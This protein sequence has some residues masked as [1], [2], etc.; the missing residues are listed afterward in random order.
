VGSTPAGRTKSGQ[1]DPKI[2]AKSKCSNV[3]DNAGF[4]QRIYILM[5]TVQSIPAREDNY[6]YMIHASG[7]A[8]LIDPCEAEPCLRLLEHL[9]LKLTH[10]LITHYD[11]DHIGGLETLTRR[12]RPFV[13]GPSPASVTIDKPCRGGDLIV[14]GELT[15]R[16]IDTPGHARPHVAFYEETC[17]WLFSGDCLFGAGCGRVSG[18]AYD[19][20]WKSIQSITSLPDDTLIFFGHEYTLANLAFAASVEPGN[21]AIESRL[22]S[23]ALGLKAGQFSS[24]STLGLERQTNPFLRVQSPEIRSKIGMPHASEEEVF[25]ALRKAKNAFR[26]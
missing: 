22:R 25:T 4:K 5:F 15:F 7:V 13:I 11:H 16:V 10:I 24:P 21:L 6:A 18:N 1:P 26:S 12:Y 19:I 20:M 8:L 14:M 17:R 3:R 23:V 9:R 2:N